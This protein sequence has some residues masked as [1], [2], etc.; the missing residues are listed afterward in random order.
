MRL[1]RSKTVQLILKTANNVEISATNIVNSMNNVKNSGNNKGNRTLV[2]DTNGIGANNDVGFKEDGVG[3]QC[4]QNQD[5][6]ANILQDW[7]MQQLKGELKKRVLKKSGR[8]TEL[9][10][11]LVSPQPTSVAQNR[12]GESRQSTNC[13]SEK[14]NDPEMRQFADNWAIGTMLTNAFDHAETY[15]C[16]VAL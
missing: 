9:I 3:T 4:K 15:V 16:I 12:G 2:I 6:E 10:G 13:K 7:N 14:N 5:L 8:N 11:R 1:Q